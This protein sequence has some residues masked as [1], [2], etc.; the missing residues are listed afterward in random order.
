[1]DVEECVE[2]AEPGSLLKGGKHEYLPLIE[3]VDLVLIDEV[4]VVYWLASF[5]DGRAW[6]LQR[7]VE[8]G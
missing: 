4:D 2:V 5:D 6:L 1:L 3:D 8:S 7:A